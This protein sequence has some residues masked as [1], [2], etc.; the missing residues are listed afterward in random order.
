M[1]ITFIIT[2][3][4]GKFVIL[5]LICTSNWRLN[6]VRWIFPGIPSSNNNNNRENK[7]FEN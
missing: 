5:K 4:R 1:V 3:A 7:T 2:L 6:S